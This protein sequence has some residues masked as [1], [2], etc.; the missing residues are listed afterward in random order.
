MITLLL[1]SA[2]AADLDARLTTPDGQVKSM[3]FHNVEE[4][5]PPPFELTMNGT[6]VRVTLV[7][8]PKAQAW[9][10][11]AQ[12]AGVDKRGRTKVFAAPSITLNANEPGT[13]KQGARIPIPDT[14]PVE[15][16]EESWQLDVTVRPS[17]AG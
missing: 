14:N 4:S 2:F 17:Q 11:D 3:T 6:T 1:S 15:F 7:A 5:A 13:V 8:S 16:R 12:L 10:V 9:V